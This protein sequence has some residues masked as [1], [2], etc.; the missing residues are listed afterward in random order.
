VAGR[1]RQQLNKEQAGGASTMIRPGG[2]GRVGS[3]GDPDHDPMAVM[4]RLTTFSLPAA[5]NLLGLLVAQRVMA[6]VDEEPQKFFSELFAARHELLTIKTM[7]EQG[8][9]I[10][11]RAIKLTTF[12]SPDGLDWMKDVLDQYETVARISESQIRFQQGVNVLSCAYRHQDDHCRRAACRDRG[13]HPA[14]HVAVVCL[15]HERHR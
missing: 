6:D 2:H 3:R 14:D 1:W 13:A 10:Y 5:D 11:R 7:A 15:G 8:S 9:D 4:I 12:A